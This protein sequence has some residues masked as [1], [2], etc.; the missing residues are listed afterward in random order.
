MS[1]QR[2]LAPYRSIAIAEGCA[3]LG[4]GIRG[5]GH[6]ELCLRNSFGKETTIILAYSASDYRAHLNNRALIRRFARLQ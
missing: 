3:I 1:W 2:R 6:L 4:E 5:N